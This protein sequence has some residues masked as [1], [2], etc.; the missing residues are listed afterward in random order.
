MRPLA[1]LVVLVATAQAREVDQFSDRL[2]AL[3]HLHDASAVLDAR[4]NEQLRVSEEKYRALFDSIDEGYCVIE[5]LF[6]DADKAVDYRLL[7]VNRFFV[8]Q[9]G[10]ST[11]K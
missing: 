4:V 8:K 7:E 1:S 10:G 3:D 5:V 6:D 11:I 9:T 2:F